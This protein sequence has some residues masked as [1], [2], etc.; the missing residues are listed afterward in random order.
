MNLKTVYQRYKDHEIISIERGQAVKDARGADW[1]VR[2][3]A[4]LTANTALTSLED[5]GIWQHEL[6][7][8]LGVYKPP[9][10]VRVGVPSPPVQPDTILTLAYPWEKKLILFGGMTLEPV[11]EVFSTNTYPPVKMER[12]KLMLHPAGLPYYGWVSRKQ[13]EYAYRMGLERQ[14]VLNV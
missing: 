8:T 2:Q 3:V 6:L 14:G 4:S 10:A 11:R 9:S 7:I 1:L 13:L 5:G 12:L